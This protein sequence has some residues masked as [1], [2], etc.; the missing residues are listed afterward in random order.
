[1]TVFDPQKLN[2]TV[3]SVSQNSEGQGE[4]SET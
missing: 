2:L 1:M 3:T 4:G